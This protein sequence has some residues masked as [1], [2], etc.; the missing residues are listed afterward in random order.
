MRS[1]AFIL[2][3]L[4]SA[5]FLA[6]CGKDQ[7]P[8]IP[9]ASEPGPFETT[10]GG[11]LFEIGRAVVASEDGGFVVAGDT[12]SASGDNNVYVVKSD[13][14]GRTSMAHPIR[15]CSTSAQQRRKFGELFK[16]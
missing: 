4:I 5:A 11:T 10:F 14:S 8:F 12:R 6:A 1:T 7:T 9:P 15:R 16:S 3:I 13:G 2:L